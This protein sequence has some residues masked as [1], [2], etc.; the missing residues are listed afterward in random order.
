MAEKTYP[1]VEKNAQL[2]P[3]ESSFFYENM[4]NV[5]WIIK[6]MEKSTTGETTE[7][8]ATGFCVEKNGYILS[9][10]YHLGNSKTIFA[11]GVKHTDANSFIAA[12]LIKSFDNV[13]VALLKV[14]QECDYARTD[15]DESDF[16]PGRNVFGIS[17]VLGMLP[18]S[19]LKGQ[20]VSGLKEKDDIIIYMNSLGPYIKNFKVGIKI[21]FIHGFE[22]QEEILDAPVLDTL[23]TPVFDSN[24][25]VIGMIVAT[26]RGF[27]YAIH[28]SSFKPALDHVRAQSG[29]GSSKKG[30]KKRSWV[31]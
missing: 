2:K 1:F 13:G 30:G 5:V 28:A 14:N 18:F 4:K 7:R 3:L 16:I 29:E 27:E 31:E 25:S 12:R 21:L 9:S 20:L 23:G 8:F 24:G 15:D 26:D 6:F 19:L 11:R 10:A 17:H 22:M